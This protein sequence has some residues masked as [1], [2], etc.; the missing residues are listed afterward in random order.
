[1]R[2]GGKTW[3]RDLPW[4]V[5]MVL[6]GVVAAGFYLAEYLAAGRLPG[7]SSRTGGTGCKPGSS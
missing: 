4:I 3:H 5:A 7:G 1:M 6:L 2:I